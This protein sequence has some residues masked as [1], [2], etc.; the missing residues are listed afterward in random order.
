[1]N[2]NQEK[3]IKL[4]C[5]IIGAITPVVSLVYSIIKDSLSWGMFAFISSLFLIIITIQFLFGTK[6]NNKLKVYD[7][8]LKSE[9]PLYGILNYLSKKV[10]IDSQNKTNDTYQLDELCLSV[11]LVNDIQ[12]DKHND[13]LLLWRFNGNNIGSEPLSVIHL[14]IGGDSSTDF[15]NLKLRASQCNLDNNEICENHNKSLLCPSIDKECK[16][17][18]TNELN[19]S[20]VP[21]FSSSTFRLLD[22]NLAN[23][24]EASHMLKMKV[25]YMWPQCFNPNYDYLLIDPNN[26]GIEVK[27]LKIII[28]CD[29]II[30]KKESRI[31]LNEVNYSVYKKNGKGLFNYNEKDNYFYFELEQVDSKCIYYAEIFC[32]Q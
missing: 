2:Q 27:K 1:M 16:F 24:I 7:E 5:T 4:A 21:E 19:C 6:Q 10:K 25:S 28:F 11:K 14:R 3:T 26:F 22:I 30:I 23:P 8:L 29:D 13:L 31:Q 18:S 12:K 9:Y 15:N 32:N 17:R 20:S